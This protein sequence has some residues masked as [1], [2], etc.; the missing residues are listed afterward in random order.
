MTKKEQR[1]AFKQVQRVLK[2][3]TLK[4][5]EEMTAFEDTGTHIEM[6]FGMKLTKKVKKE[7]PT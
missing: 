6:R 1:E 5:I 3:M 2:S 4:D 7:N